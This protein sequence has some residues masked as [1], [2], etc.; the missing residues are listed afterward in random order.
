MDA[1]LKAMLEAIAQNESSGG[2]NMQHKMV[3][4]G[5][6]S[7]D[8][9]IGK[10]G[11]MPNTIRETLKR[12]PDDNL[13]ELQ[14]MGGDEIGDVISKDRD[15]PGYL[16]RSGYDSIEDQL[17][18]K[19]GKRVLE[20]QKGDVPAAI[21]SWTAGHNT[22]HEKMEQMVQKP[23]FVKEYTDKAMPVYKEAIANSKDQ[24][25]KIMDAIR[26]PQSVDDDNL[27]LRKP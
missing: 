24:F 17:A 7:G 10:Y 26:N 3:T 18:D 14:D 25:S 11:M 20:K 21:G 9:A 15:I 13:N 12:S 6:N 4:S 2:E 19:L 8:T 27:I 23:G 5:V 1:K 16:R 22:P